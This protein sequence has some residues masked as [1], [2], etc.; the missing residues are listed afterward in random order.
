MYCTYFIIIKTRKILNV[1][2][3]L[4]KLNERIK[5]CE[6]SNKRGKLY[7]KLILTVNAKNNLLIHIYEQRRDVE[8]PLCVLQQLS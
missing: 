4:E 8:G 6:T 1:F 7:Q 5:R 3:I 2:T